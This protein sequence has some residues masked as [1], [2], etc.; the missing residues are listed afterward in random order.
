MI[1]FC[2][3]TVMGC[4]SSL[5]RH[6]FFAFVGI[7]AS[8]EGRRA[9]TMGMIMRPAENGPVNTAQLNRRQ[10]LL[11]ILKNHITDFYRQHL[12]PSPQSL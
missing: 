8:M 10:T 11:R 1:W 2:I 7:R 5:A 12:L 6:Y 3:S 9:L 4:Q